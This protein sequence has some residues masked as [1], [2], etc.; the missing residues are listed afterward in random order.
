VVGLVSRML[1]TYELS[2]P[3]LERKL[4]LVRWALHKCRRFTSSAPEAIIHLNE[5][6]EVAVL[7]HRTAHLKL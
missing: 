1:T 3:P 6:A 2:R 5:A 7:E 4:H